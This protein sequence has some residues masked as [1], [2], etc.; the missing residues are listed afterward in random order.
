MTYFLNNL[1]NS[2]P[3]YVLVLSIILTIYYG[4]II[5]ITLLASEKITSTMEKYDAITLLLSI[6]YIITYIIKSF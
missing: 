5:V 6:S 3:V 1:F 2:I 4:F